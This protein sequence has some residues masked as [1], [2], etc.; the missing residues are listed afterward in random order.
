MLNPEETPFTSAE[1]RALVDSIPGVFFVYSAAG[2]LVDWNQRYLEVIGATPEEA[3]GRGTDTDIAFEDKEIAEHALHELATTGKNTTRAN[4]VNQK[5]GERTPFLFSSRTVPHPDGFQIIGVGIDI[6]DVTETENALRTEHAYFRSVLESSIDGYV[7]V[8]T[9]RRVIARNRHVLSTAL[10]NEDPLFQMMDEARVRRL[11]ERMEHPAAFFRDMSRALAH[12]DEPHM[13]TFRIDTGELV[14]CS[15]RP[16]VNDD[17]ERI[18]QILGYRDFTEVDRANRRYEYLATHDEVT[19]LLNRTGIFEFITQLIYD[20]EPFGILKID[21]DRFQR[22]NRTFGHGFGDQVLR[23]VSEGLVN[24]SP[25]EHVVGRHAGDK[26]LIAV[27]G[28]ADPTVLRQIADDVFAQLKSAEELESRRLDLRAHIGVCTF[29]QD[30]RSLTELISNA[31]CA[32]LDRRTPGRN[33]LNFYTAEMGAERS[34]TLFLETRMRE[35]L[36]VEAFELVYQPKV[37][38]RTGR[39]QGVET[40]LRW[41]DE[42]LGWVSP[43]DFIPIAEETRLILPL[44]EWVLTQACTQMKRWVDRGVRE[45]SLAVNVSM[46]QFFESSFMETLE[47]ILRETGLDPKNLEVELTETVIAQDPAFLRNLVDELHELGVS[48][49]IDDFGT[50]YSSLSYL[51]DF[52]VDKLKIDQAFTQRIHHSVEDNAII[53]TA[54]SIARTLGMVTIAEGVETVEQLEFLRKNDCA[55][56]QGYLFSRPVSA[57]E[58]E[59]M[60]TDERQGVLTPRTTAN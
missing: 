1:H 4:M 39:I 8:D 25:I 58:I 50:G 6:T 53:R 32:M 46:I 51:K 26:F 59:L 37:D 60:F 40:L 10:I 13:F 35:A 55:G 38:I 49:S 20:G 24:A 34:R 33:S 16:V 27:P 44:G 17:G 41:H 31:E 28:T 12:P 52:R 56:A 45:I 11:S 23:V 19:G 9:T 2:K 5:T 22:Y 36:E 7:I 15:A 42:E 57:Q 43:A 3:Y 18:G 54:I 14:E 48:V 29:P 30:G 47:G 21:I